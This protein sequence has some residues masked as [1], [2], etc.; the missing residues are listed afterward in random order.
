M[1]ENSLRESTWMVAGRRGLE[2][3][4]SSTTVKFKSFRSPPASN[5]VNF[6]FCET[7]ERALIFVTL[8]C[9]SPDPSNITHQPPTPPTQAMAVKL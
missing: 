8:S 7:I 1:R 6:V 2:M 4:V 5:R 3:A 9:Q